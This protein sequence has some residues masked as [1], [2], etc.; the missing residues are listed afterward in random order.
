MPKKILPDR[1]YDVLKW[2]AII[3]LPAFSIFYAYLL[4][5]TPPTRPQKAKNRAIARIYWRRWITYT[6][7]TRRPNNAKTKRTAEQPKH[8]TGV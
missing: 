8:Y 3:A 1:V 4:S 5:S 6:P 7:T 2:V